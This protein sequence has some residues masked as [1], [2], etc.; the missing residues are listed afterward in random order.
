MVYLL[1]TQKWIHNF[2]VF[3]SP[4][5]H[6]LITVLRR[7]YPKN[8]GEIY[9]RSSAIQLPTATPRHICQIN[10]QYPT[11]NGFQTFT[12]HPLTLTGQSYRWG[13]ILTRTACHKSRTHKNTS[14]WLYQEGTVAWKAQKL[15]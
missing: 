15:G 12:H 13:E 14:S 5:E 9:P 7:G 10:M 2:G 6:V 1:K 11:S 8:K 3:A 4:S